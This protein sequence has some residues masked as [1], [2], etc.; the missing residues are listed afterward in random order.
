ML[1]VK[2]NG[3]Y[4]WQTGNKSQADD[5]S[6]NSYEL[7]LTSSLMFPR[8]LAPRFVRKESYRYDNR[9]T[10]QLS[11][12]L[13]NRPQYFR[14]LSFGGQVAWDFQTSP[15]SY[16]NLTMFKM[17]YNRLLSTTD[18]FESLM[19]DRERLRRSFDSQF[20]PSA[21]YT[22]TLD[23]RVGRGG[24]NRIVWQTTGSIAGNILAGAYS[25]AGKKGQQKIFG[26]PFFQYVK[27]TTEFKYNI[28]LTDGL[29][30]ATRIMVGAGHPYGNM[31]IMPYLEQFSVGG[32]NS[33][34][35]FTIRSIG[36][37]S[38]R[39]EEEEKKGNFGQ[40]GNFKLEANAELRFRIVGDLHGA[41]FLDAGNIWDLTEDPSR[42]GSKF[43][44]RNF[45][46]ELATG[47]GIGVRYDLSFLVLRLDCGIGIH[48]PYKN[49]E[50]RGYYNIGSFW[51]KGLGLHLAIGYPF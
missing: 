13:L 23:K 15:V 40:V 46:N 44:G 19:E 4:E 28:K 10:F 39:D 7:G 5:A 3:A 36:P 43:T 30:L 1:A 21:S 32:A 34:R 2:L 29:H 16:H 45:L 51:D 49:P 42:P 17:T 38:F 50:K 18:R 33:I 12:S 20:I 48:T 27:A 24:R 8:I 35:A 11:A 22:Y 31:D 41:V 47:T 14:M 25:V 9:T 6:I 37:G 26:V